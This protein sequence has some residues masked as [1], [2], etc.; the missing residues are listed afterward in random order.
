MSLPPAI[1]FGADVSDGVEVEEE[2]GKGDW[3]DGGFEGNKAASESIMAGAVSR[4]EREDAWAGAGE[5][6][7]LAGM[8]PGSEGIGSRSRDWASARARVLCR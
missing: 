7:A 3:E 6:T 2:G 1:D 5:D 4:A 8:T